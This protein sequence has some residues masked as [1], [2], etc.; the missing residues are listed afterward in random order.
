MVYLHSILP[1]C[2]KNKRC[3]TDSQLLALPSSNSG[4]LGTVG[5]P[6]YVF[7]TS[8]IQTDFPCTPNCPQTTPI[9]QDFPCSN[10]LPLFAKTSHVPP[11]FICAQG[12]PCSPSLPMFPQTSHLPCALRLLKY[13]KTFYVPQTSHACTDFQC[14]KDMAPEQ[15]LSN[16]QRLCM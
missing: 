13:P 10:R 5:D 12:F 9:H 1:Y 15:P 7:H 6:S 3:W 4:L 2:C 8:N 14:A 11:D 16:P